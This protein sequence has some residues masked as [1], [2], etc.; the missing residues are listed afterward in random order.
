VQK[1]RNTSPADEATDVGETPTLQGSP[2]R[3][4]YGLA[5]GGA[6]FQVAQDPSFSNIIVSTSTDFLASWVAVSQSETAQ[7]LN[8]LSM[9]GGG[10]GTAVG[11]SGALIAPADGGETWSSEAAPSSDNLHAVAGDST[12]RIA[13]G[14]NG[15]IARSIYSSGWQSWT[16]LT[17]AASYTGTF[18]GVAQVGSNIIAV[19][20]G[21]T[22]QT[23]NDGGAIF[24]GR[25][26]ANGF[27]GTFRAVDMDDSGNAIAVG[28][29]GTI[30]TSNDFGVNWVDRSA[31]NSYTGTF[32]AVDMDNSAN[33]V[34]VGA[35]GEVQTTS[36]YGAIWAHRTAADSFSGTLQAVSL[37]ANGEAVIVGDSGEIQTTT[38]GGVQWF[39]RVAAGGFT[40]PFLGVGTDAA[41]NAVIVGDSGQVQRANKLDSATTTFDVPPGADMLQTGAIYHWRVRYQDADGNWSPW[42]HPTRFATSAVFEYVEQPSA[43]APAPGATKVSLTPTLQASAFSA[44]GGTDTHAKSQWQVSSSSDFAALTYNSGEVDDLESHAVPGGAGL[45]TDATYYWRVR[46]KGQSMGWSA[47]SVPIQFTT[48]N[49]PNTPTILAPANN[50]T[51]V[52]LRPTLQTSAFSYPGGGESHVAT[53][54]QVATDVGFATVVYDSGDVADLTSHDVPAGSELAELTTHYV[55]ARHKGAMTGYSGWSPAVSFDTGENVAKI[56]APGQQGFGVGEYPDTLPAGYS[57]MAGTSDPAHDNYGNYTYSDGSVLVFIPR[58]YYRVGH[59]SNPTYGVH[60]A[61][62]IDIK[63][64]EDFA[65]EAAANASGYTMHRAFIDGGSSKSG[66]FID[67]YLA[68]TNGSSGQS[69]KNGV[70]ISLTSSSSYTNSSS[71]GYSGQLSDAIDAARARG[72]GFNCASAFMYSALAML[73]LAH[74]QAAS[75]TTN[76]AWYDGGGTTNYPKGCNSSLGDVDDTGVS[77]TT[78]GDSGTADKPLTGSGMPFAK[79]THNGQACGVADLNG[80][81]RQV[82]IGCTV[83][84]GS[85]TA[86][87]EYTTDNGIWMLKESVAL[88]DCNG[89]WNGANDLWQSSANIGT[90]YDKHIIPITQ[91]DRENW[92][93]G[94]TIHPYGPSLPIKGSQA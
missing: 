8:G 62:S 12:R 92:A 69:V 56:G 70:P 85:A 72:S 26:A 43:T 11:A 32:R 7:T 88:V 33:A 14:A 37:K 78:A 23:S 73:S 49:V 83:P 41:G 20:D 79:T 45:N 77:Y 64:S 82:G 1:P 28:D 74:A 52:A 16:A 4:V 29:N 42:S 6:E 86:S 44:V 84:G 65:D 19:G 25:T 36:A 93:S 13:V 50:A 55:R 47:W 2:F 9:R 39:K 30:Q 40:D 58:F 76:C 53:Q 75:G 80:C 89:N 91:S 90:L 59:A 18:Y 81:L 68:S 22:I 61:N 66:F 24:N 5:Q 35:S 17:P 60:G 31:D 34:I 87:S 3:S 48:T 71:M 46:Y 15:A 51:D 63:G 10:E 94:R 57:A 54:Y 27:S 38:D 21:G 67:K